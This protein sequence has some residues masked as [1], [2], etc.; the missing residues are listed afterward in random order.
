MS[1]KAGMFDELGRILSELR[2]EAG[3]TQQ[4]LADR[5]GLSTAMISGYEQGKIEPR[6]ITLGKLLNGLGVGLEELGRRLRGAR[7]P[8]RLDLRKPEGHLPATTAVEVSE[9]LEHLGAMMRLAIRQ[10][11]P[12]KR[13]SKPAQPPPEEASGGGDR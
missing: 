7:G 12:R 6:L 8:G 4:E 1:E 9:I 3:L 11:A 2:Q 13:K 10:P 5:S